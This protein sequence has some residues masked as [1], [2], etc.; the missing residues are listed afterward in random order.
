MKRQECSYCHKEVD[1][2]GAGRRLER[3]TNLAGKICDGSYYPASWHSRELEFLS[4]VDSLE[5]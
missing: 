2:R 4:M 5:G 3:H 1:V